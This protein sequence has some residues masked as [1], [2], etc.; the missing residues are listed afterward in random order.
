M[1]MR[2]WILLLNDINQ[3]TSSTRTS[4]T[5]ER[6]SPIYQP[7]RILLFSL[8][9]LG[10]T[11]SLWSKAPAQHLVLPRE[12]TGL[13]R[14]ELALPRMEFRSSLDSSP[15]LAMIMARAMPN[16]L[17]AKWNTDTL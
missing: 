9:R 8:S 15:F 7:E 14:L 2:K 13:F 6:L 12:R 17:A 16:H 3:S 4:A 10:N 11:R 1:S 5:S